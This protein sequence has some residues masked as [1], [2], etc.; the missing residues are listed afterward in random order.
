MMEIIHD[1]LTLILEVGGTALIVLGALLWL[2]AAIQARSTARSFMAL[3]F[4]FVFFLVVILRNR[5]FEETTI[6]WM[7]VVYG[8]V[9]AFYIIARMVEHREEIRLR[10]EEEEEIVRAPSK[11]VLMDELESDP[12]IDTKGISIQ[13]RPKG[14][15]RRK[16][17]IHILGTINSEEAKNKVTQIAEKH[18][19]DAYT[20][21]NE[22]VVG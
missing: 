13:L 10:Q 2:R 4:T 5:D 20:V 17:A 15:L 19:G 3:V 8:G 6:R 18:A 7:A 11:S 22:L 16:K 12:L 9:L 14:F 1:L 21:I